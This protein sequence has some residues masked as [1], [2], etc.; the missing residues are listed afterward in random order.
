MSQS[1]KSWHCDIWKCHKISQNV[2]L[3]HI[4]GTKLGLPFMFGSGSERLLGSVLAQ[5]A[6]PL[7]ASEISDKSETRREKHVSVPAG[8]SHLFP[9]KKKFLPAGPEMWR[10][11][12]RGVTK[13]VTSS[14]KKISCARSSHS[15]QKCDKCNASHFLSPKKVT[16]VT[17]LTQIWDGNLGRNSAKTDP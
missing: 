11:S 6:F 9:F 10:F 16:N 1:S 7:H 15:S 12:G 14:K 8:S 2:T 4:F 3:F 17:S 5:M 13:N